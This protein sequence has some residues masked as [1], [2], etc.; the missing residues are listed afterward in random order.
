M[1]TGLAALGGGVLALGI[2]LIGMGALQQAAAS[3]ALTACYGSYPYYGSPAC[4]DLSKAL[5]LWETMTSVGMLIAI[6]GFVFLILGVALPPEGMHPRPPYAPYLPPP[7]YAPPYPPPV[8]TPPQ[9]PKAPP[10]VGP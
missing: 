7:A 6:T 5:F 2:I 9:E 4:T 10:P 8:Y 3:A 1:R